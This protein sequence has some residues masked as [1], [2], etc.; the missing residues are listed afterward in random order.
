[1]ASCRWSNWLTYHLHELVSYDFQKALYIRKHQFKCLTDQACICKKKIISQVVVMNTII[2]FFCSVLSCWFKSEWTIIY[3]YNIWL[4][5]ILKCLNEC[6]Y[7]ALWKYKYRQF[8]IYGFR[9]TNTPFIT[10]LWEFRCKMF[11]RNVLQNPKS[12]QHNSH[13]LPVQ[14]IETSCPWLL[15]KNN[16]KGRQTCPNGSH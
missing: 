5:A 7:V 8:T 6:V 10:A 3:W 12:Y 9:V 14:G 13:I 11:L 2:R 15:L 16:K 4:Q 1:M